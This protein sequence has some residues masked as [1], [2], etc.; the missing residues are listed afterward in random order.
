VKSETSAGSG[1]GFKSKEFIS[2]NEASSSSDSD[3][4]PLKRKEK[5]DS[6]SE[7]GEV[8]AELLLRHWCIRHCMIIVSSLS[9]HLQ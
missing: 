5:A 8:C 9:T 2:D 6:D 7:V 4:K 1:A 3:D